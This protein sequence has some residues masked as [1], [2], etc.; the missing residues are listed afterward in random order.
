MSGNPRV[1]LITGGCRGV[2]YYIGKELLKNIPALTC[3]MTS[4]ERIAGHEVLL[5]MELGAAARTRAK[6]INLDIRSFDQIEAV[7]N[8]ICKTHGGLDILINNASIYRP[9]D[10]NLENFSADVEQIMQ[11]NYWGNKKMITAFWHFY[12]QD[13]RI[14]N[15]TSH[16]AHVMTRVSSEEEQRKKLSRRRFGDAKSMTE[17]DN[18]VMKFQRDAD[19]G[20]S[21]QEGWP[22]C[23]YSVSKMAIN[24]YTRLL[25]A[26]LDQDPKKRNVV[27]NALY[28]ATH[29]SKIA[30]PDG[31]EL[32]DNEE[33]ARFV[34][35]MSTV[36]ASE[37]GGV[38]PRGCIIWNCSNILDNCDNTL[39]FNNKFKSMAY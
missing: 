16:L 23:A 36:T 27:V 7:K 2:G 4:R 31:L 1:A 19:A 15:I 32:Y 17:L 34:H 35:Y 22:T 26:Q 28:P 12:N 13:S 21:Q 18:L 8:E 11:T 9:P 6:F 30:D 25:Q 3:Y 14:V 5:G 38:F 29:H 10:Y 20:K 24:T 33:G 39:K 37:Y